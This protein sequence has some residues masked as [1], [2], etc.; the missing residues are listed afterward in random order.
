MARKVIIDCDPGI[1]DAVAL[2]LALFEPKL[3]V[4][5]VTA[6]A[7]NVSADQ[8][9]RNVQAIIEQIDPPRYPRIGVASDDYAPPVDARHLHGQDGLGNSGFVVSELH[10]Q[11]P[12]EKIICD[13]VHADP[14]N[15]TIISLGPLTNIARAF[16]RDVEVPMLV[17]RLI[18]MGGSVGGIGN[19]TAS[20]EFNIY[21]DPQS[22][23]E[24]FQSR[25][26]KTLIPL[27][28]T[29]QIGF[30]LDLVDELPAESTRVGAFLHKIVPF[31]FRAY[32]QQLGQES[33]HLHDAVALAAAVHGEL[34]QTTEMAGDVETSGQLTAG[35]TIFDRRQKPDWRPNMEVAMEVDV[36][37]IK[38]YLMRGLSRA[39]QSL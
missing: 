24:V 21:C 15:V 23:R 20:A 18:I 33:I 1:D 8:A 6:T 2:C 19:V 13:E 32:H 4:V 16:R 27:D 31:A 36:A 29:S 12:S 38:D 3:E 34:F 28:L 11:H 25:T 17:D 5:G 26:T 30:T 7:G 14:G 10:H 39:A 22:A 35:A 9:S 37:A